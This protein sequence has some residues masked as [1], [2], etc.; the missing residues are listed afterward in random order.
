MPR[1]SFCGFLAGLSPGHRLSVPPSLLYFAV[2]LERR[3]TLYVPALRVRGGGKGLRGGTEGGLFRPFRSSYR[4]SLLLLSYE[5]CC[6]LFV[7]ACPTFS[8]HRGAIRIVY[9]SCTRGCAA[10][11]TSD[12]ARELNLA[13]FRLV[14]LKFSPG[15]RIREGDK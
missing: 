15:D 2:A 9:T 7:V 5:I 1:D 13:F 12:F 4:V 14:C 8:R 11:A 10:L 6:F 3:A